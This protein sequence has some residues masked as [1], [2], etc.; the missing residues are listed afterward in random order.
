MY[1]RQVKQY[2][3]AADEGFDERKCGFATIVEFLRAC[4][5]EG[6]FR[7]ERDRQGVLRVFPGANLQ[8]PISQIGTVTEPAESSETPGTAARRLAT[9]DQTR[10]QP[11]AP[12]TT[13]SAT[14]A[15][16]TP[17]VTDGVT[18]EGETEPAAE[19]RHGIT[20]GRAA[21]ACAA[22]RGGPSRR[23]RPAGQRRAS[24]PARRA[25]TPRATRGA[26]GKARARAKAKRLGAQVPGWIRLQGRAV[27]GRTAALQ[28]TTG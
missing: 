5:R 27:Q 9:P 18:V 4:Q 12:G 17:G 3:R 20:G 10:A 24:R 22:V 6:V 1:V 2:L 13:G 16:A 7:L 23:R 19:P 14:D 15:P 25:A 26:E 28:P 21:R 8:R 11:S